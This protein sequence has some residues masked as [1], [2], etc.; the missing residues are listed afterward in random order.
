MM[1]V[2]CLQLQSDLIEFSVKQF[3]DIVVDSL[4]GNFFIP[5]M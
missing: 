1:N 3:V 4:V 5:L 2:I